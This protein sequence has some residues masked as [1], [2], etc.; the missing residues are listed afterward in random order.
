MPEKLKVCPYD[1]TKVVK[2]GTQITRKGIVQ[3][4]LCRKGHS[5]SYGYIE[6][7]NKR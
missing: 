4:W 3:K 6:R 5:I 7:F 2:D 1:G